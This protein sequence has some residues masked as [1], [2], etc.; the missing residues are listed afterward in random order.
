VII[1]VTSRERHKHLIL[2][3]ARHLLQQTNA[4]ISDHQPI[5]LNPLGPIYV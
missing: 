5:L 3:Q 4:G 2:A 1:S